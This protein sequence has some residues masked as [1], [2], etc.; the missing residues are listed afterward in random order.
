MSKATI[1]V[2]EDEIIIATDL[3]NKLKRLDY[4]VVGI[5]GN[6][7]EAI[8]LASRLCP[9]LILMDISL[10][11]SIDGVAAAEAIHQDQDVPVVFLTA[12][13]DPRTLA[14]AKVTGPFGYILKPFDERELATQIELA[15]YKHQTDRQLRQQREW[16]HVTLMSIADAVIA[17]D[18][19]GQIAFINPVAQLLTGWTNEEAVG[20][21]IRRVVCLVNEQTG[22]PIIESIAKVLGECGAATRT[23]HA[24][25]RTKDGRTIPIDNSA[26]PI[27]DSAGQVIGAVLVFRDVTEK[28]RAEEALREANDRYEL[29][30]AGAEAAIWDWDILRHT[31]KYS[32]RWKSLRGMAGQEFSN[33]E[34]VWSQNIHPDDVSRVMA[35]VQ[36][37]F[38]GAT[39]YFSE[40]YRVRHQDGSWIWIA[41]RGLARRD[42]H[43]Q[44]VRMAGSETDITQKRLTEQA[45]R[46]S[47]ERYRS[48]FN[49]MTNGFAL[50][51]VISGTST[52]PTDYRFVEVNPAFEQL[53]TF[54]RQ[55][56]VG[57]RLREFVPNRGAPWIELLEDVVR[58][59][60]GVHFED[61]VATID[62]WYE[63]L[64]FRR[65]A[66]QLAVIVSDISQVKRTEKEIRQLNED[67]E[68]RV[69]EQTTELRKSYDTV[70]AE[71]QRLYDLLETLPV[72]VVL[73]AGENHLVFANRFFREQIGVLPDRRDYDNL[74]RRPPLG[75][76]RNSHPADS[77]AFPRRREPILP[78]GR[79]YDV[80][81]F[82]FTDTDGARL[83]LEMG[84]D[85]TD[86]RRAE[87]ETLHMKA[88]LAHVDRT[89]RMGE[90]AASLA[91]EINQ[92]LTA[93][94]CNAQAA[95][96]FVASDRPDLNLL[97][98]ILDDIIRDDKRAGSVIHRLRAMI[99]KGRPELET[100][101]IND[102]IG[103]VVQLLH[104][105]MLARNVSLTL[106]LA[107][108]L[109]VV[110]AGR[111]EVQQV[112][113]NLLLNALDSLRD[114][115]PRHNAILIRTI[116]DDQVV[117][118]IRDRGCGIS[119]PD[120]NSIFEPFFT[121]KSAGLGMGLAICRRIVESHGG[122][123]WATNNADTGA[124][125]AFSLPVM[126]APREPANA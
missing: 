119:S 26:A 27:R 110:E 59:G 61:Y 97:R 41:D 60:E 54:S 107:T 2:V 96:R 12:H 47:E 86:R 39:P 65:T 6:G 67:L 28:R 112:L 105:E 35:A 109:P 125:V 69:T 20:Q 71:R 45:L 101:Q 79:V 68:R 73:L 56:V 76:P 118:T 121:T 80:Y 30:L 14:R 113:V 43:G 102:V 62:R 42:A 66:N 90:L 75:E 53:T 8:A 5:T 100:F 108:D 84:I 23:D 106:D 74:F 19:A 3:S 94:L 98:E 122:R 16:L 123:I 58:T 11:G 33:S 124:T 72:Y 57:Q 126:P 32:S 116:R 36:A 82:P 50:L 22:E 13:S 4:E 51:D 92:P 117:V 21:L 24:V 114:Q 111:V 85:I 70:K 63:V 99:Q 31:V 55:A 46:E 81:S 17:F 18:A 64:V 103:E 115:L 77:G 34:E 83:I 95:R 88:E 104:S 38:A 25:L 120:V 15:L 40:E 49:R 48:L 91:H 78:D 10:A 29:V 93:I 87:A 44:V 37:H 89:A 9:Q 1:L 7:G 52:R